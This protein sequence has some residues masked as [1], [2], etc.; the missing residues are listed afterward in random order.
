MISL[1]VTYGASAVYCNIVDAPMHV[2]DEP[3]IDSRPL[4]G[5]SMSDLASDR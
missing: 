3:S 5:A 4:C 2:Q 1:Q